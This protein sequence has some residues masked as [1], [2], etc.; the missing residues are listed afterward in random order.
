VATTKGD[1]T[2]VKMT[3]VKNV[4]D[5]KVAES[6]VKEVDLKGKGRYTVALLC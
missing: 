3:V 6:D 5:W 2:T 4:P 1:A